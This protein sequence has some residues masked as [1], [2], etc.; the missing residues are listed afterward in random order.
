MYIDTH[1]HLELMD[2]SGSHDAIARAREAGV[3]A[4]VT[5]GIDLA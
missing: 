5:V 3:E 2:A 4:M 1:C